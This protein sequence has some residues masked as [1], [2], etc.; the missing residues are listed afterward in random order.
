MKEQFGL[1][2]KDAGN[3]Y[4]QPYPEW[5]ERVPLPNRFKA[6]EFSK[7]SGQDSTSTY[8]H[9]SRFLAQCGEASAVD[10]LRV[11]LFRLSLS[12]LAFT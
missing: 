8:K 11:R 12:G 7:F 3:L 2:P 5:F 4:R 6:P 10:A 1:R 9:I